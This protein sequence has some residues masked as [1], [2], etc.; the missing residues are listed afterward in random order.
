TLFRR[1]LVHPPRLAAGEQIQINAYVDR[2]PIGLTT[3]SAVNPAG[4][5]VTNST[6]GSD[7]TILVLPQHTLGFCMVVGLKMTAGT[8]QAT[9]PAVYYVSVE[10]AVSWSWTFRVD[11]SGRRR[12]LTPQ[13]GT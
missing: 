11:C 7:T 5:T 2:D 8:S 12:W 1:L 3:A 4:A 10:A 6:V 9:T 13:G